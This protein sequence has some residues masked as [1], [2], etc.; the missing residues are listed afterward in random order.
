MRNAV[1]A[2]A[3]LLTPCAFAIDG[4]VLI[5][6]TTVNTTGGFP[7]RITQT[8]SYK[9]SGNLVVP[10]NQIGILITASNVVLD[11]NGFDIQCS[12]NEASP[13]GFGGGCIASSGSIHNIAIRNGTINA[14]ATAP[15]FS[16]SSALEGISLFSA[17]Q[18]TVENMHIEVNHTNYIGH[19]INVGLDSIVRH[20]I[21]SGNQ[22]G[23]NRQCPSLFV[24]NVNVS[25][26]SGGGGSN[27]IFLNNIGL[28]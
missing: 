3:A 2:L 4:L 1:L 26:G 9:L 16:F 25:A 22:G 28:F 12:A 17:V 21:L 7:Y 10:L 20:N 23:V 18:V 8:G 27:C 15:S 5:N 14:S 19:A 11:L 13:N 24:E 6:Q